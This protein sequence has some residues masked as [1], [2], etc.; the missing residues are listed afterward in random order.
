MIALGN[1]KTPAAARRIE[2]DHLDITTYVSDEVVAPGSL[3]SVVFDVRS[4]QGIH[5][6]VPGAKNYKIIDLRLDV[7][8]IV[9]A[10]PL[11]PR[12]CACLGHRRGPSRGMRCGVCRKIRR[13]CIRSVRNRTL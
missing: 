5:V 11:Q 7:N 1:A 9:A 4:N 10:R 12:L 3:F 13:C 6:Y 2:T 8:P